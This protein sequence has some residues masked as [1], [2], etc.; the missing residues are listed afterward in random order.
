LCALAAEERE[1][2]R[3]VFHAFFGAF[4]SK[5]E[6]PLLEKHCEL[7]SSIIMKFQCAAATQKK[8]L[9]SSRSTT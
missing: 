4:F 1:F 3:Q 7:M 8:T 5:V 6:A 9:A 2:H